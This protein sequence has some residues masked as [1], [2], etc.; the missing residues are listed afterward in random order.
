[1]SHLKVLFAV[2]GAC[3]MLSGCY[4]VPNQP[5]ANAPPTYSVQPMQPVQVA[6][7]PRPS[8]TARLYPVN[9]VAAQMGTITGLISNP[10]RGYGQF[11]F[12]V[13]GESYSGEATREPS[14]ANGRANAA[15][16]RGGFAKCEYAMTNSSLGNGT[17][18][19]STGARYEMHISL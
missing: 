15:G 6:P 4:V 9:N 13:G 10:E 11:T 14:S 8:Y 1:M 17:C 5:Y 3:A 7:A 16:N 2:G 19:F 18:T 12:S